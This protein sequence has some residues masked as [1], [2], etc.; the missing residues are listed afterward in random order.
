MKMVSLALAA[1]VLGGTVMVARNAHAVEIKVLG[2]PGVR[3]FY[4]E[5]LP[6]FEKASGHKVSTA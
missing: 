3:E 4:A 2:T 1:T 5:L 6:Q